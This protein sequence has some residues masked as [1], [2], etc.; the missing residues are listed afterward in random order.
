MTDTYI[1][2]RLKGKLSQMLCNI[3]E[4]G[5][6]NTKSEAIRAGIL[7]LYKE[8]N[9][10]NMKNI[11]KEDIERMKLAEKNI[12]KIWDKEPDGLWESYLQR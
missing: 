5:Y 8:F 6:Y 4:Q 7:H 11:T 1:N 3:V 9:E 10:L 2:V 12:K